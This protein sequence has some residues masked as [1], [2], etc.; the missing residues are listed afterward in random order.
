[1]G[2]EQKSRRIGKDIQYSY[3]EIERVWRKVENAVV[4][5]YQVVYQIR[6]SYIDQPSNAFAL[7][8]FGNVFV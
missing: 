4:D 5:L 7:Y 8:C 1:M 6:P 3:I 2:R